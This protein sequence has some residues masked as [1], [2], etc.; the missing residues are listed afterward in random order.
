[1]DRGAWWATVHGVAKSQTWLNDT[2]THTHTHTH[3]HTLLHCMSVSAC[4]SLSD[5]QVQEFSCLRAL[6]STSQAIRDPYSLGTLVSLWLWNACKLLQIRHN[7]ITWLVM[8]SF[9]LSLRATPPMKLFPHFC[10][11]QLGYMLFYIFISTI[12]GKWRKVKAHGTWW[13]HYHYFHIKGFV[14]LLK[15][16]LKKIHSSL[17]LAHF[18]K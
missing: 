8:I 18:S 6:V 5:E 3:A 4:F 16:Q 13:S 2:H 14:Q 17:R 7:V 1:M 15:Q 12:F 9:L 10:S 11:W